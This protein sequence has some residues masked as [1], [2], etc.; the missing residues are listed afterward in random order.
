M[1]PIN[2]ILLHWR[3]TEARQITRGRP[4]LRSR[5]TAAICSRDAEWSDVNEGMKA[6]W[7]AKY[8]SAAPAEVKKTVRLPGAEDTV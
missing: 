6:Y 7:G 2:P 3:Q 4:T 8:L 1:T 5:W